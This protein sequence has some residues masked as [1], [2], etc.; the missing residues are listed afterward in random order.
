[1]NGELVDIYYYAYKESDY[2]QV[3]DDKKTYPRN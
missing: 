2:G 1:M 3:T